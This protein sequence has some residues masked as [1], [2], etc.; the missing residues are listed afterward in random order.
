MQ[1][2]KQ[3]NQTKPNQTIAGEEDKWFHTFP[4]GISSKVNALARLEIEFAY[5]DVALPHVTRCLTGTPL[6]NFTESFSRYNMVDLHDFN[7]IFR[8]PVGGSFTPLQSVYSAAPVDWA[9]LL[10]E[11]TPS[12]RFPW[13]LLLFSENKLQK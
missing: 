5:Y 6:P 12:E 13:F 1:N 8:T 11:K 2:V 9:S 10:M 7:V 4:K 3:R